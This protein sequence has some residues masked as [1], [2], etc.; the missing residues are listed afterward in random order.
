MIFVTL[1][2]QGLTLPA[3]I[4]KLGLAVGSEHNLEEQQARLLILNTVL[5]YL[6]DLSRQAKSDHKEIYEDMIRHYQARATL[7]EGGGEEMKPEREIALAR[8]E[9]NLSPGVTRARTLDRGHVA[10]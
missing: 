3:V 7:V 5:E 1:V 9:R 8:Y 10:Q 4:R 2:L 6:K